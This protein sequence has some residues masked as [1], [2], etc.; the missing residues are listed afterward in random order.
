VR[1]QDL[2]SGAEVIAGKDERSVFG[3]LDPKDESRVDH[4]DYGEAAPREIAQGL[5]GVDVS[6]DS[7][8]GE[9]DKQHGCRQ[10]V[11]LRLRSFSD[12]KEILAE[13][14]AL[15]WPVVLTTGRGG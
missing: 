1:E 7:G 3:E 14:V 13:I 5:T 10:G 15:Q 12:S 6:C 11:R 9:Q 8:I 4:S 2:R